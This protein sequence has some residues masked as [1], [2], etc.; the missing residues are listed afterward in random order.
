MREQFEKLVKELCTLTKLPDAKHVIDGGTMDVNGTTMG[1]IY[2]EQ[3]ANDRCFVYAEFGL[4]PQ[5]D[6]ATLLQIHQTLL[7]RNFLDFTGKGP[8]FRPG[9]LDRMRKVFEDPALKH[10]RIDISWDTVAEQ[11]I[12]KRAN[13]DR[14]GLAVSITGHATRAQRQLAAGTQ[15]LHLCRQRI[16]DDG[17][18][19]V[20]QLGFFGV[21]DTG[22]Q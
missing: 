3:V 11:L 20:G 17:L 8:C 6:P 21:D 12:F 15:V 4:A 5:S 19:R 16:F 7:L 1:L 18:A 22:L 14:N 10:V 13:L 2:N 9:H